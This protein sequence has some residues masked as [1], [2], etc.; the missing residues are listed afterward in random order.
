MTVSSCKEFRR[1]KLGRWHQ[2]FITIFSPPLYSLT[3]SSI[4]YLFPSS[5]YFSLAIPP[6]FSLFPFQSLICHFSS[7]ILLFFLPLLFL[8]PAFNF[9]PS[10]QNIS[11]FLQFFITFY[12]FSCNFLF[13]RII[14]HSSLITSLC[15]LSHLVSYDGSQ[16]KR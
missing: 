4:F 8:L 1:I 15:H 13:A 11:I 12:L 3:I 14:F 16:M 7:I 2:F 9:S 10:L 6:K 5:H